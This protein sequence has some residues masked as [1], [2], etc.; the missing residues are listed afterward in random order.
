Q[1]EEVAFLHVLIHSGDNV[2]LEGDKKVLIKPQKNMILIETDKGLYK[3]GETVKFRIVNLDENLKVIKN[4]VSTCAQCDSW[5]CVS[6]PKQDPE[7]NHIA[8]WLNVK[9]NHGIVDLSFPLASEASLGNYTISVQQNM[10]YKKFSV[11]EYVLKKIEV[12]IEH[13]PHITTSDEEFQLVVCGEYTYGKPVQGKVEITVM[14]HSQDTKGNST[15]SVIQKQKSWVGEQ[16][17]DQKNTASDS[18]DFSFPHPGA[19]SEETARISVA[20]IKKAVEFINLHP[21][22]KRGIPYTG[23][24][25]FMDPF[26][27]QNASQIKPFVGRKEQSPGNFSR[28]TSSRASLDTNCIATLCFCARKGT[29]RPPSDGSSFSGEFESE[30]F[31]WLKPF[32]SESNSF[33]EI[34]AKDGMML[35]DQEQEVRFR[36]LSGA[37]LFLQVIA[38]GKI[39]FSREKKGSFSLTL[40]VG[41]DFLPDIK[42]LVYAIFPDGEVVADMEEFEVEMCFSHQVALE[43]SHKEEVP[44]SQV[45]LNLLAAPGSLC[46][47]R[48]VDKSVL[49]KRNQILTADSVNNFNIPCSLLF[50]S[51]LLS[52]LFSQRLRMKIFTNTR[53]KKPVSCVLPEFHKKIYLRKYSILATHADSKPHSDDKEKPK[54]RTLFPETWIWDLVSVGDDGQASLQ[55]AVPDTITEWNANTFCVADIGFGFSPLTSLRVFQPFFVD[56]SLPYSVIQGETFKLKATVFNYLKDCIQVHT[57]LTETPELKVD[58]CPGCQFTSCL[59]A[60]EAKTFVWNVTATKL[61]EAGPRDALCANKIAVT[62]LQGGRDTVIK[63]LLVKPGGVLQEKTQNAFLCPAD[64]TISEEF[65]LT[66]PAEVL[67]GSAR[68]T[69]S[70]IGDIMGPALQNLDQLLSMPFGC[71]EQNMVQFAPNI[72]ILQYLNK[73]KQLNPEIKAIALTFLT[74]GYQRQ[75]LYKH[76]DGSYSAFGK[77]DE[78]GNTWLTAFVARS[79]GQASSHI[80]IDKDHV[81]SA[82]RWLQKQQ[83]PSGCFQSVGKLFNNDLKGGVDDT[84]SL[85]AYIAAALLELHLERNDTMLENALHC[86]K[87]VTLDE[88]SLYVKALMAYVF[89]L[90]KDMEMRK[91]LLD[92]VQ[93]ETVL[94]FHIFLPP[95]AQLLTSQS[96]DEKSSSMIET[97]AYIVLA[98]VSKPDLSFNEA[99]VSKLVHWLSAQRNAFGGFASTQDT[100]VSL[101]ALAQYA[102]LI[103]QEM[104]DVKVA[105]KGKGASPLEFHVHRNNKLVLHQASLPADTGS[106][107]V[108]VTGSGCVYVQRCFLPHQTAWYYNIPPPKPEEV[109]LLDV[110]TVPRECDGVRKEFDIH[111]SVRYVGDRGT[112]NMAL[113]EVEMLSGFIPVQSSVKELEKIPLVKKTEIKPDKITIYLEELGE[114]S[115]KL[116]I[117]VEQ[118]V[119]VQNLKAA[120]VHVYDYYKPGE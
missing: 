119:E 36:S 108:Q 30:A 77:G 18:T 117:S 91:Q 13:P 116:N 69:F 74:T 104:R 112:S 47:V 65:S 44:G 11:E 37:S 45:R 115:L 81:R 107:T 86:L 55:V 79:F 67:E 53:I 57:T 40:P 14:T 52:V 75:L 20:W 35:C 103:P 15:S 94:L 5:L 76:D 62:P 10:A 39:L 120:T 26:S 66:L 3:P 58:A 89:T 34:K 59:C 105:V 1:S 2:R 49:L 42:L 46:S 68:V 8:E 28:C 111:V 61:G 9:S 73:T 80:Y 48:A 90:S 102:A 31:H 54:P 98:H 21:F 110:E 82:L 60:N 78:Q 106:Y 109:F 118:D 17:G 97:V 72:F 113:V 19:H 51:D 88:T 16:I 92:M 22:Y 83:L 70:V 32:Y 38:K 100:V 114:S 43:F 85:T 41:N 93:K 95:S 7:N 101:Q 12:K 25:T 71:G 23:K 84:I 96:A 63:S 24:V 56:V 6:F 50:I 27:A 99:S 33:L 64:N 87:K 29:H 4:E